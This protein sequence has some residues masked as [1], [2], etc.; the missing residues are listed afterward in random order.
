MKFFLPP[1]SVSTASKSNRCSVRSSVPNSRE[2][3]GAGQSYQQLGFKHLHANH[4]NLNSNDRKIEIQVKRG[5]K[6]NLNKT[7]SFAKSVISLLTS[8]IS[9]K[10]VPIDIGPANLTMTFDQDMVTVDQRHLKE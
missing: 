7:K 5:Q 9:H 10:F 8:I 6:K 4:R 1:T 2:F 3:G